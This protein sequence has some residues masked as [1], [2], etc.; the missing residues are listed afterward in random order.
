MDLAGDKGVLLT[1]IDVTEREQGKMKIAVAERSLRLFS[2]AVLD[3]ALFMTDAQGL[4]TDCNLGASILTGF[5]KKELIGQSFSILFNHADVVAGVMDVELKSAA[6][7]GSIPHK[8]WHERRDGVRYFADGTITVH[9]LPD[10]LLCFTVALRDTTEAVLQAEE[11]KRVHSEQK[12]TI[13]ALKTAN[14]DLEQFATVASHDMQEP[15]RMVSG[16]LAILKRRYGDQFDSQANQYIEFA[17][18]GAQR[19]SQLIRSLLDIARIDNGDLRLKVISADD[20]CDEAAHNLKQAITESGAMVTKSSLGKV[21]ADKDMLIRL[22]QNLIGNAIKYVAKGEH[23]KVVVDVVDRSNERVFR[24]KDNGIGISPS[25]QLRIFEAF[26]RV[27]G[28]GEYSGNGLT[29][30]RPSPTRCRC[31]GSLLPS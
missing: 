16:Y 26:E 1:L 3:H 5:E 9:N 22:F 23:P 20:A 11:Q 10:E 27:H 18:E 25:D 19:M 13:N 29:G 8:R 31:I 6:S 7:S 15:L 21:F 17:I 28:R 12:N 14:I 24:V 4:I 2:E 30:L